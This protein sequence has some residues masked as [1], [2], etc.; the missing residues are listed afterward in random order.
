[1]QHEHVETPGQIAQPAVTIETFHGQFPAYFTSIGEGK[2]ILNQLTWLQRLPELSSDGSNAVLVLALEATA[3]AYGAIMSSNTALN[4]HARDLCGTALRA[5]QDLIQHSRSKQEVTVHMISTSVL[6]G[7]F[8]AMQATTAD[9]YRSHIFGAAKM[10]EVTGPGQCSHGVLCQLFYHVRTQMLFVQLA[11]GKPSIPVS[12][13][14]IMYNTLLYKDLPTI[15][16]LM[17]CMS[18]LRELNAQR[19][20]VEVLNVEAY[21]LLKLQLRQ[22]WTEYSK[23][24]ILA[25]RDSKQN[26]TTRNVLFSDAFTALTIAYFS[27]AFTLLETLTS[28]IADSTETKNHFQVILD[29]VMYLNVAHNPIA[30]MRM[31]TPLLL[32]AMHARSHEQTKTAVN[33]F[34]H[35]SRG[36]M[37]GISALALDAV[38]RGEGRKENLWAHDRIKIVSS[39]GH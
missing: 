29:A 20:K 32:V 31:G 13:K 1:M 3:T 39:A 36:S 9:A 18:E 14:K 23:T 33:L 38:S 22:L 24:A 19:C 10:F 11:S 8:E 12:S 28:E 5:H 35:W 34:K 17:C 16:K 30:F 4:R 21:K 6:F 25:S 15:Q 7:F 2:D 37:R 27:S 26:D